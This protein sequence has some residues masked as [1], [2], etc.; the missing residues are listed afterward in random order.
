VV[1]HVDGRHRARNPRAHG[2]DVAVDLRVVGL[3]EVAGVEPPTEGG[4]RD[5]QERHRDGQAEAAFLACPG[6]SLAGVAP[7]S[8]V[9]L[10]PGMGACATFVGDL[11]GLGH[12][13]TYPPAPSDA[14]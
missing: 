10:L 7:R 12:A 14:R 5:H 13:G 9:L 2:A 4:Q 8:P 1:H 11:G 6:R 3:L